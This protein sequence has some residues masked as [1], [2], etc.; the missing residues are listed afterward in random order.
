MRNVFYR[1]EEPAD[2]S[3]LGGH[4]YRRC[5]VR[6]P[7]ITL[8]RLLFLILVVGMAPV[9]GLVWDA[10]TVGSDAGL[11]RSASAPIHALAVAHG[12]PEIAWSEWDGGEPR[13]VLANG[14]QQ[15]TIHLWNH[16]QAVRSLA[17]SLD[18]L[19]LAAGIGD[20]WVELRNPRT[21]DLCLAFPAHKGQVRTVAFSPDGSVLATGGS[22]STVIVWDLPSGRPRTTLTSHHASVSSV[23]FAP[24][25][26]TL[27]TA[28]SA[29]KLILWSW[30][31]LQELG[32]LAWNSLHPHPLTSL[33]FSPD[34]HFLAVG[35]AGQRVAL[36]ETKTGRYVCSIGDS[37]Q[38]ISAVMFS[39]D[40]RSLAVASGNGELAFWGVATRRRRA[41]LR[42]HHGMVRSLAFV[43]GNARLVSAAMDGKVRVWTDN[44]ATAMIP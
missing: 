13:V 1:G 11:L 40:G 43:P 10:V 30:P 3:A 28:D 27:A 25:G 35:N 23:A 33:S 8:A 9:P 19:W 12:Q 17:L 5:E 37:P 14:H 21:F 26:R 36:C 32:G 16:Q 18:G 31:D 24:D 20:G 44:T 38:L 41:S 6:L 22:D 7:V 4:R 34:S 2:Q 15:R 39:P 42:G 29:G